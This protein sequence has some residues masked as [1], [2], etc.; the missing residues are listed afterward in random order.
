MFL[1]VARLTPKL[2]LS[3]LVLLESLRVPAI[4][5]GIESRSNKLFPSDLNPAPNPAS[6]L[7]VFTTAFLAA[8]SASLKG[9]ANALKPGILDTNELAV[10]KN[11]VDESSLAASAAIC[12]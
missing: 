7:P 1:L 6:V 10:L 4:K 3:S 2:V 5:A 11:V 9:V 12:P 8:S